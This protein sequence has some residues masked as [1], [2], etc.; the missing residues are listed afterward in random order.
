MCR[1][2]AERENG[3]REGKAAEQQSPDNFE[4]PQKS[5]GWPELDLWVSLVTNGSG[6]VVTVNL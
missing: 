6:R 1:R 2:E 4:T 3:L 5:Q